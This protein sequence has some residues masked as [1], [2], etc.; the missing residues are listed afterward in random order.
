MS[1]MRKVSSIHTPK[2]YKPSPI[3]KFQTKRLSMGRLS[4]IMNSS[5]S[6]SSIKS[7]NYSTPLKKLN[8]NFN[9]TDT[10][11]STDS[12]IKALE[13]LNKKETLEK[14][15][16]G[17]ETVLVES[18]KEQK[19]KTGIDS[20]VDK[21][22]GVKRSINTLEKSSLDWERLKKDGK[23]ELSE[24]KKFKEDGYVEKQLFL[25]RVDERVFE[26]EKKQRQILRDYRDAQKR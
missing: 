25:Q 8:L 15:K 20:M 14:V 11:V 23:V 4:S 24:L 26:Q 19:K 21:I 9:Q 1:L 7:R 16:F 5:R 12:A 6:V 18:T 10:K 13:S 22:K 17:N 3:G 2:T